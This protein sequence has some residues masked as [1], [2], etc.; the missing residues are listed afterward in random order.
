MKLTFNALWLMLNVVTHLPANAQLSFRYDQL[1]DLPSVDGKPNPGVAGGFVG[2][3]YGALLLAGGANFP[4]GYPWQNGT[5]VWQSTIY[6]LDPV[7]KVAQWQPV[8]NLERPLAYG[9]SA[10]WKERLICLGGNDATQTYSTVFAL[11]W[12]AEAKRIRTESL[13][14]LPQPLANLS[15]AIL[16]DEL[17][18]F[19]GESGQETIKRLAVLNLL[20]P[21]GG[22]QSRAELPGPARAFTTLV[23]LPQSE[24]AG[25][26]VL[27]GRQTIDHRT[28][29]LGDAYQYNPKQ[30]SWKRL[31]NLPLAVAAQEAVGVGTNRL[32]LFGGDDGVRLRQIEALN[33]QIVS[34]P[35]H[36]EKANWI[37]ERNDLQANHPGFRREIWQF[38]IETGRWSVAG[39]L[40]FPTPVTTT[41][42]R[43][44]ASLILPSGEVSPGIRTP[45]VHVITPINP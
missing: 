12:D 31:P 7:G 22:W 24:K 11:T 18:V 40:P 1:P 17:Y 8:G 33:N 38:Q 10:A 42:V 44:G 34:Q 20:N 5:K 14:D 43:W 29:V 19:G 28:M 36:P 9:A 30:N 27:G 26:F 45:A 39:Q 16:G 41:V 37:A 25:L 2:L 23:A 4:N 35:T 13:P 3:S 6:V 32:L 21:K 15:A